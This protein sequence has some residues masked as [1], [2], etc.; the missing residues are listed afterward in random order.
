VVG[1]AF[2]AQG[3][4]H[5]QDRMW[6]MEQDRRRAAGRWAEC[7]GPEGLA[8]DALMRRLGLRASAETDYA[9]LN[10]E[11]RAMLDAYAAGVNAWLAAAR[12]GAGLPPECR[13]LDLVP[14][15]WAPWDS[16]AVFKVR[17]A[18]MG[19]YPAKLWRARILFSLGPEAVSALCPG[20]QPHPVLIVPPGIE[21]RG[22][23]ADGLASLAEAH[24][25]LPH[26]AAWEGG[27]N[28]WA[29]SG[30]RTASGKPL[31]AGDPHRP[32]D[33]PN[34]YYQNHV[35]CPAFDAVGLSFPG[36]PGFPHFGHT[37]SVAWCVTHTG[38]DCQ[39]LYVE[40]F[41]PAEP[42]RY[43]FR[44]EWR[45]VEGRTERIGVRG[46]DPVTIEVTRTHHGPV[47]LG[48]PRDG[49]ALSLRYTAI[50]EPNP[51]FEAFLP[52]LRAR[53]ADELV[54]AMHPW[55]DPV[56]NL[57]F[58]DV[59]GAIGYLTRGRIPRRSPANLWLPVP[60]W[61]GAHEWAEGF[62]PF[63]E[64]PRLRDPAA[65]LIVT[66]NSRVAD[67]D[68]PHAL[69]IDFA[70]DLRTRRLHERLGPL[71]GATARD[72]AA[73]HAD[74]LSIPARELVEWMGTHGEAVRH[75]A[76][77]ALPGDAG[78]EGPVRDALSQLCGWGAE[79]DRQSAAATIYAVSRERLVRDLLGPRLG[80]LAAE[81]FGGAPRGP[82]AHLAR[83]RGR[84]TEW[85]RADERG[86]LPAGLDWPTVVG[87]AV[88]AAVAELVGRLGP[89]PAAWR[90]GRLH[91]TQP[92]HPLSASFPEHAAI[93]DPPALAV[94]GDGDT[95][96][97]GGFTASQ[98]YGVTS[99]SVAR[100]VFDLGDWEE[101]AWIVPLGVSGD[102]ASPHYRDQA[103][104]WAECRLRPMR[105]D[106]ARIRAE[107]A[108]HEVLRPG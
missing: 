70:L 53:S 104:D 73:V 64:M 79:M 50:A 35:A 22:L 11:T 83:L 103:G 105:Y 98:G 92:R 55:V 31:V 7:V 91:T 10:G 58:A 2:F 34:V 93:L 47:I 13:L 32:L 28:N 36:V 45:A 65:G 40:R 85:I 76:L 9:G 44:G 84:L 99:L 48:E 62:V 25:T 63:E 72:M 14:E 30:S 20:T 60:G 16:L 89:D 61:D 23:A 82:L 42:R 66:A 67:A 74:C 37:R 69:G 18:L 43:R 102:P 12:A 27:S 24:L 97:Q 78:L 71:A 108:T 41:D 88:A 29:L 80:P 107:A 4:V 15:P 26:L 39:D 54:A 86:L 49:H 46:G 96:R 1:D 77:D 75:A 5:A 90:W 106:W 68:Y 52:M 81:L 51:T 38:A 100:Y 87:R 56:N 3:F 21:A 101:S 95:V 8:E 33:V 59:H 19:T 57:V 17:H 6:H 94:S